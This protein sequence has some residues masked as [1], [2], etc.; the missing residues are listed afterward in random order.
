MAADNLHTCAILDDSTVSCWRRGTG[1]QRAN[2][3]LPTFDAYQ[4]AVGLG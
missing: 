2:G 1:G 3:Y 4:T